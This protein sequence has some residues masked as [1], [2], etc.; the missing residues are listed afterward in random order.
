MDKI[1]WREGECDDGNTEIQEGNDRRKEERTGG[2]LKQ[3]QVKTGREKR[4]EQ[5][6]LKMNS[7]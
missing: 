6:N 7:K 3:A 2:R 5:E 1:C 4:K